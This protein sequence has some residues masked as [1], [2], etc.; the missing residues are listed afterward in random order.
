MSQNS[1][2]HLVSDDDLVIDEEALSS[3]IG[4]MEEAVNEELVSE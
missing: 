4:D 1:E 3:D 2:N